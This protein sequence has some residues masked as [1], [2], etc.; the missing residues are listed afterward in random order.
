M[1]KVILSVI[2]MV[3]LVAQ[4]ACDAPADPRAPEDLISYIRA[5]EATEIRESWGEEV[6]ECFTWTDY[7]AFIRANRPATV[8]N[9]L[10]SSPQFRKLAGMIRAMP[11]PEREKLLARARETARPTW[12]M[13]G[14]ISPDGTTDAG[15]KAG[16]LLAGAI[17]DSMEE[18][19]A[20]R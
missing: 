8:A 12:A 5:A 6:G 14:R 3:S 2:L 18:L 17:T 9:Q 19:L 10:K 1:H 11:Q 13:I 16:L 4:S 20:P 7:D 15:R